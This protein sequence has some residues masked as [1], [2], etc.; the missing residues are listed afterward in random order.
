MF[1]QEKGKINVQLFII[2]A[3]AVIALI[4]V[5]AFCLLKK[6]EAKPTGTGLFSK[7][8]KNEVVTAEN[9]KE[10]S[11]RIGPE[12]NNEDEAYQFVYA[13]MYYVIQDGMSVTFDFS[14][15]DEQKETKSYERVYGKTVKQLIDEGKQLMKDNDMTV[16][17]F[18]QS[19]ENSANDN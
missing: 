16:E 1:K 18:K 14:L 3:V 7:S 10:L 6:D 4:C 9:Y 17:K 11:E 5:G 13:C 12:L 2:I 8:I 15:T 19:M